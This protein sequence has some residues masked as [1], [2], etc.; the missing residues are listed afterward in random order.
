ME[1]TSKSHKKVKCSLSAKFNLLPTTQPRPSPILPYELIRLIAQWCSPTTAA[2][3][4]GLDRTTSWLVSTADLVFVKAFELWK[5]YGVKAVSELDYGSVKHPCALAKRPDVVEEVYT[6]LVKWG[7]SPKGVE[8]L[9]SAIFFV[10]RNIV[11]AMKA[12]GVSILDTLDDDE[13]ADYYIDDLPSLKSLKFLVEDLGYDPSGVALDPL[14]WHGQTKK[15]DYLIRHGAEANIQ[16][17]AVDH[18]VHSFDY[19]TLEW[20]M[21]NGA[22]MDGSELLADVLQFGNTDC[23]GFVETVQLSLREG[24]DPLF[25]VSADESLL[26]LAVET[27]MWELLKAIV[28]GEEPDNLQC[29]DPNSF[30]GAPLRLAGSR[31]NIEVIKLLLDRGAVLDDCALFA[32]CGVKTPEDPQQN[33]ATIVYLLS[34]TPEYDI[35]AL[36]SWARRARNTPAVRAL[37][38]KA[39]SERPGP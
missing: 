3:V 4:R 23:N 36:I 16:E 26:E 31:S 39:R 6:T 29:G 21:E 15:A 28:T 9:W 19:K 24:V 25:E 38:G 37:K 1:V 10:H 12:A 35:D 18:V 27:E 20:L 30:N 8:L 17:D 32:A 11:R 34:I 33:V 13:L 7:A 22:E 5:K 2:R 14:I